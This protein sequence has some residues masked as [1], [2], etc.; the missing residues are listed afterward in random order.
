MVWLNQPE[1]TQW[2]LGAKPNPKPNPFFNPTRN[3]LGKTKPLQC[4]LIYTNA[5]NNGPLFYYILY[6]SHEYL[7]IKNPVTFKLG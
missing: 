5:Y 7:R 4:V 1:I 3:P 2:K 6:I